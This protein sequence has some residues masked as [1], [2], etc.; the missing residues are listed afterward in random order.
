MSAKIVTEGEILRNTI[1]GRGMIIKDAAKLLGMS[2]TNLQYYLAKENFDDDFKQKVKNKLS[3]DLFNFNEDI[4]HENVFDKLSKV[5]QAIRT[6]KEVRKIEE[7]KSYL[8]I[9]NTRLLELEPNR[10]LSLEEQLK[11]SD[12]GNEIAYNKNLLQAKEERVCEMLGWS[13]IDAEKINFESVCDKFYNDE[14]ERLSFLNTI[15]QLTKKN[16]ELIN[17]NEKLKRSN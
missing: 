14:S 13:F 9:L 12:L 3:I 10:L 16:K 7:I 1:R 8:E 2:R 17:E 11:K 4:V 5:K 6:L 15:T